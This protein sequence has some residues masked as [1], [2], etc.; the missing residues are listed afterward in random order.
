MTAAS[1]ADLREVHAF[2]GAS[3]REAAVN[4]ALLGALHERDRGSNMP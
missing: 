3:A 1:L 4:A 2:L